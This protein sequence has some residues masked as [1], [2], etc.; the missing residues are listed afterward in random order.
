[1]WETERREKEPLEMPA[2]KTLLIDFDGTIAQYDGWK[3]LTE[4]G[5]PLA[6]ARHAL[7]ILS[8]Q[9]RIVY[10][11]TRAAFV[12]EPWLQRWGFPQGMVTNEKVPAFLIIDD[13]AVTFTGQWTDELIQQI[14]DFKPWWEVGGVQPDKS[15]EM[16]EPEDDPWPPENFMN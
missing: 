5:E 15:V 11:T 3:G 2:K 1:M 16:S 14:R 7:C 4:V 12:V 13:R 6:K 9:F 10:F 8:R